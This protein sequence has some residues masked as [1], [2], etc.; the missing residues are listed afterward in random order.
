MGKIKNWTKQRSYKSTPK[1]SSYKGSPKHG[2][3]QHDSLPVQLNYKGRAGFTVHNLRKNKI[4]KEDLGGA[5]QKEVKK[6]AVD[7][8]Q[9]HPFA[10]LETIKVYKDEGVLRAGFFD[11]ND[12]LVEKIPVEETNSSTVK[13]LK[14]EL[15]MSYDAPVR[16]G[17]TG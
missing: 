4:I 11:S 17:Y 7:W 3:W 6:D 14:E 2:V 15:E 10:G 8:M 16:I 5:M 1:N 12:G 9:D 13:G